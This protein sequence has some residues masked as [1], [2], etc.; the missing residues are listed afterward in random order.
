VNKEEI[1]LCMKDIK[2]TL[3]EHTLSCI[4]MEDKLHNEGICGLLNKEIKERG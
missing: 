4:I 1:I 2:K 3:T